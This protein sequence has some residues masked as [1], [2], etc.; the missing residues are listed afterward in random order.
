[1]TPLVSVVITTKN[2]LQLLQRAISSVENQTYKNIELVIV[3]DAS[4]DGTMEFLDNLKSINTRIVHNPTSLGPAGAKNVG[5]QLAKGDYLTGLDDDDY[6]AKNRIEDFINHID[7][8]TSFLFTNYIFFDGTNKHKQINKKKTINFETL[9]K[10][11]YVGNQVF[12]LTEK[13]KNLNGFDETLE[14]WEDYDLWIRLVKKYGAAKCIN[15]HSYFINQSNSHNR[16]TNT[17]QIAVACKQLVHKH[18][19]T[20]KQTIY[21]ELNLASDTKRKLNII[22]L[23]H[24]TVDYFSTIRFLKLFVKRFFS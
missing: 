16:V 14:A 22:E 21:Q 11:N 1:M 10:Q 18:Q 13:I 15:N 9:I 6:F 3:N 23:C 24:F 2:R 17:K 7:G 5:I 12:I 20:K 4:N 19:L 8:K